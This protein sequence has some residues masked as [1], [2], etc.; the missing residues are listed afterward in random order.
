MTTSVAFAPLSEAPPESPRKRFLRR[1][2]SQRPAL[3]AAVFV[4]LLVIC[5]VFASWIAPFDPTKQNLSESFRGPSWD[6]WLGTNK[7]GR[8]TFSRLI[9]GTRF[10]LRAGFQAVGIA[11]FLGVP[12]GVISGLAGRRLDVVLSTIAD[13]ILSIPAIVLALAIVGVLTPNLTSA[14]TAI[15]IVYSPRIFRVVRASTLSIREE[16]FIDAARVSGVPMG[17]IARRHILPN[18]LSPLV[19]QISLALGFAVLA[20]A[21]LSFLGLGVQ[22][23]DAS[24]GVMLGEATNEMDNHPELL[25]APGIAIVLTVLA[26][27][28]IGDGFNDS[29][30]RETR[31]A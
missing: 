25:L 14:M 29:I 15:G 3:V 16:D 11:A 17:T 6:H 1:F 21:A 2:C 28:V 9:F 5:A 10:T 7:L 24:W 4:L 8:D 30:G 13:A 22:P 19:V 12:V 26:F 23:P 31:R 27:N 18:I 20:E